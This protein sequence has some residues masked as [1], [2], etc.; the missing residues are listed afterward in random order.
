MPFTLSRR[1]FLAGTAGLIVLH[2]FSARAQA[3][4]DSRNGSAAAAARTARR[5][6]V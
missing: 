2:P 1:G 3:G 5:L 4:I 6:M